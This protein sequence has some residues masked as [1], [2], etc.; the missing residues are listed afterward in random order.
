VIVVISI[1]V[2]IITNLSVQDVGVSC[3]Y[4]IAQ[5]GLPLLLPHISRQ[6]VRP[7]AAEFLRLI[8]ERSVALPP[9]IIGVDV[10]DCPVESVVQYQL[11]CS[12]HARTYKLYISLHRQLDSRDY[13]Q[14]VALWVD[15]MPEHVFQSC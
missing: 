4:R 10:S 2:F 5:E 8:Q 1:I 3:A 13:Y 14:S 15:V 6:M 7:T 12:D 11:D 9:S